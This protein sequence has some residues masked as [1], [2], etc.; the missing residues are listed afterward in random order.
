MVWCDTPVELVVLS[1]DQGRYVTGICS[2]PLLY[3]HLATAGLLNT[4]T[5]V[6]EDDV[7]KT[8]SFG[9]L[10]WREQRAYCSNM[11]QEK[12]RS[13]YGARTAYSWIPQHRHTTPPGYIGRLCRVGIWVLPFA[14]AAPLSVNP[15]LAKLYYARKT[16]SEA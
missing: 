15:Q 10:R 6:S 5:S 4:A 14:Y 8:S 16:S 9:A 13:V 1:N 12:F 7:R 3:R 2:R 11:M